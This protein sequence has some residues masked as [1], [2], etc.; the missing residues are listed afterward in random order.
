MEV[1]DSLTI[2][3]R[4]VSL[5]RF[6]FIAVSQI[7]ASPVKEH[8]RKFLLQEFPQEIISSSSHI[9]P[10]VNEVGRLRIIAIAGFVKFS[11]K[12]PAKKISLPPWS[13]LDQ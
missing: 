8:M 11:C 9:C 1:Q 10:Q 2:T 4:F 3:S 13:S 7:L 12:D 5:G 6:L